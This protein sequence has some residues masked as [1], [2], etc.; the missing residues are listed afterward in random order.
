MSWLGRLSD[1]GHR[2]ETVAGWWHFGHSIA[3]SFLIL[4]YSGMIL[5]HMAAARRHWD[6]AEQLLKAEKKPEEKT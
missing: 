4:G 6:A 2:S 5:W 1:E 3:Y